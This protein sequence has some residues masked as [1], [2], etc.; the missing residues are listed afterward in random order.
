MEFKEIKSLY[1]Q[2]L[3]SMDTEEH[4]DLFFYRPLGF[5]WAWL[6]AKLGVTPNVVTIASIF[7]GVGGGI[8]LYFAEP[9][10]LWLNYVG[11][12]L[13][14]WANTYD[15]ADGQLA[16]L[17]KQYSRIG[18]ILDGVS[19]DFWF[20]AI[21]FA[22]VFREIN[23][24]DKLLGA[25][26]FADHQWVI[27][28]LAVT[29]GACHAKQAAMADYYRQF[30]HLEWQFHEETH[31]DGVSQLYRQPGSAHAQHATPSQGVEGSL[32][33][34]RDSSG[35]PR[36]FP[37]QVAPVDEIHQYAVVQHPHHRHVYLGDYP[38]AMVVF[39]V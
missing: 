23:F 10:N 33:R 17:T 5:A 11:I 26:F 13:I 27:W 39:C 24:G 38:D 37:C 15:S 16:R 30:H 36:R 31:Y 21:Y 7:L 29:A 12:F 25:D 2:S 14:I 34:E 28:V 4:I 35:V 22:L 1:R 20:I 3:K 18:R 32:R 8:L 19:G 9:A 6:F